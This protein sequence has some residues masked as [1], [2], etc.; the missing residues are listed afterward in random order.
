MRQIPV[1]HIP[2]KLDHKCRIKNR[3]AIQK[4][5]GIERRIFQYGS[6]AK[7]LFLPE[8]EPGNQQKRQTHENARRKHPIH[9]QGRPRVST[10]YSFNI[11]PIGN[12]RQK[13]KYRDKIFIYRYP[14]FDE[15]PQDNHHLRRPQQS[16]ERPV[17]LDRNR[18]RKEGQCQ[19]DQNRG[20]QTVF[21]LPPVEN[22]SYHSINSGNKQCKHP[23]YR[24]F[25]THFPEEPKTE[26]EEKEIIQDHD[27]HQ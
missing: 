5:D 4:G 23:F 25:G 3:T 24:P 15:E 2:R 19:P 12:V 21:R 8:Q 10:Q 13:E 11:H 17:Q 27:S 6:R 7:Q 1:I 14:P 20:Q 26:K 22:K 16:D 9:K 18:D